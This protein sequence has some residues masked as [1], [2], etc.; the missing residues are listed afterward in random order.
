MSLEKERI[1]G[2]ISLAGLAGDILRDA[3]KL[4]DLQTTLLKLQLFEDR[5]LVKPFAIWLAF[6]FIALSGASVSIV[7]T[8][9]Y[10]LKEFTELRLWECFAFIT[11]AFLLL[12]VVSLLIAR[13]KLKGMSVFHE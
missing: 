11:F 10:L 12:T 3:Q 5:A 13:A 8:L 1:E 9:V 7:L 6:G 2:P 4:F